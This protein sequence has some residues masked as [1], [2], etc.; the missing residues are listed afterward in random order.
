M[1]IQVLESERKARGMTQSQMARKIGLSERSYRGYICRE[2]AMPPAFQVFVARMLK[3]PKLA[4]LTLSQFEDNPFAPA[5]LEVDDH[6]AQ[7]IC[8]ALKELTEALE[9]IDKI[10][11]CRPDTRTVEFAVDQLMDLVH[12]APVAISSWARTY[13]VD[14]WQIRQ[15]NLGKLRQRGYL[16]TSTEGANVA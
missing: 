11:P 9:A 2:R 16:R 6:P 1:Y 4:A 10:D 7:Q 15:R 13:G 12:L 5:A 8:V 3:S 14:P